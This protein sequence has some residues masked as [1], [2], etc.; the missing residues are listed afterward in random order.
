MP[1][2]P[3][4]HA[5]HAR[6]PSA[7][8]R[9]HVA[10]SQLDAPLLHSTLRTANEAMVAELRA[11]PSAN[12]AVMPAV[13]ELG[14]FV[15]ASGLSA[16]MRQIFITADPLGQLPAALLLFTSAQLAKMTWSEKTGALA[17]TSRTPEELIDGIP[18][19]RRATRP[20]AATLRAASC[21][22][23]ACCLLPQLLL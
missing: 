8:P 17:S 22:S 2:A 6:T 12:A 10:A 15:D 18:M 4:P 9:G 3:P 20:R 11:P 19:A 7:R 21:G 16:P 14:H 1:P 5:P 23:P 13:S